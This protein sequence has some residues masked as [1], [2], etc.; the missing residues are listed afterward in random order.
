MR[1]VRFIPSGVQ[2]WYPHVI[3][4]SSTH[5]AY[6]S[7]M[8]IHVFSIDDQSLV[9]IL[10]K[11]SKTI[12]CLAFCPW[13]N[14]KIASASVDGKLGVW[15][16]SY[17]ME[18]TWPEEMGALPL[19]IDWACEPES[20]LLAV[21]YDSGEIRMFDLRSKPPSLKKD[22]Q[23]PS[24]IKAM[25]WH[26]SV[27]GRLICGHLDGTLHL[28]ENP[29]RT[30][31]EPMKTKNNSVEDIQW[32]P[33]SNNY[34]LVSYADGQLQM[35]DCEQ[36]GDPLISFERF[37]QGIRYMSWVPDQPGNFI[38]VSDKSSVIKV[39]NV[40]QKLPVN[41]IKTGGGGILAIKA[42]PKPRN[43]LFIVSHKN[44]STG[45]LDNNKRKMVFTTP[46][47]HS[48]TIFDT[49]FNPVDAD[50]FATASYDGYVKL[51][52][53]STEQSF[54][55]IFAGPT[56]LLYAVSYNPPG[57]LIAAVT[58]SG[59]ILIWNDKGEELCRYEAHKQASIYRLHWHPTYPMIA[60]GGSDQFAVITDVSTISKPMCKTRFRH[61]GTV[62]GVQFDPSGEYLA[63]GCQDGIVRVFRIQTE[64]MERELTGHLGKVFNVTW[65]PLVA[66]VLASGS[67]DKTIRIWDAMKNEQL[68][69]LQG[70]TSYVR[71]LVWHTEC[72]HIII[73]GSW[74]ATIRV[75]NVASETCMQVCPQHQAD[76]YGMV[77]H[78]SRP[79]LFLSCSRDTSLRFWSLD[80]LADKFLLKALIYCGKPTNHP[81]L[82]FPPISTGS[83]QHTDSA[84]WLN[85]DQS[86]LYGQQ[87]KQLVGEIEKMCPDGM[88][89]SGTNLIVLFEKVVSFFHYRKGLSDLWAILCACRGE[90]PCPL[91]PKNGSIHHENEMISRHRTE[92]LQLVAQKQTIGTQGRREDRLQTAAKMLLRVGY[93]EE[94]CTYM[95]LAGQW[96][97]AICM[98]PAVSVEFWQHLNSQYLETLSA[99]ADTDEVAPLYIACEDYDGY[100]N[101]LLHSQ[102][103]DHAFLVAKATADNMYP[104]IFHAPHNTKQESGSRANIHTAAAKLAET[105]IKAYDPLRA[106]L[107][108]FAVSDVQ[109]G[110]NA[111]DKGCETVLIFVVASC[112]Q[113][114][115]PMWVV[116]RLAYTLEA[117]SINSEEC[118]ARAYKNHFLEAAEEMWRHHSRPQKKELF[119]RRFWHDSLDTSTAV[120]AVDAAEQTGDSVSLVFHLTLL[121]PC[122]A[123]DVARSNLHILF[124]NP[125]GFDVTEA[126]LYLEPFESVSLETLPVK[127]IAE[128]LT[129]AAFIGFIDAMQKGYVDIVMPL[130]QTFR[131]LVQHQNLPFPVTLE[132]ITA[133]EQEFYR[134]TVI[135]DSQGLEGM[136][137]DTEVCCFDHWLF[138]NNPLLGLE[139]GKLILTG[140]NLPTESSH[141]KESVLTSFLIKG[142][143]VALDEGLN[144]ISVEEYENWRRVN[145]FSPM[146][147]GQ[148]IRLGNQTY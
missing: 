94:Y 147:T 74:D 129:C 39:W 46:P 133:V 130:A 24:G 68:R 60:T 70:H 47:G 78:P 17:D 6:A 40:S 80:A 86:L 122:R 22:F 113:I 14:D 138:K 25:R 51:W 84:T 19:S 82:S 108:Y 135:A 95:A 59:S 87:S 104:A 134:R 118:Y 110:M 62:I 105:Y 79:F 75:W 85:C 127:A 35:I 123:I 114:Q 81:H 106:S 13:D 18:I 111:L 21:S 93:V 11:H 43:G 146:N 16:L 1:Q 2:S 69:T 10:V 42:V 7:T 32:D 112:L 27:P 102:E 92:A 26:P 109:S 38:T 107:M 20:N 63:T 145:I 72:P 12:T 115:A 117:S 3:T 89:L 96:E 61:P 97:K 34:C 99:V 148:K 56:K 55:E 54:R 71:A 128:I 31:L 44:G 103:L 58:S 121:D 67:D 52:Q 28:L 83:L 141:P 57:T 91:L 66:N 77:A 116:E 120:R 33:L 125:N 48:E 8:A 90:P 132:S 45:I 101:A 50:I 119:Q 140:S 29:K 100:V 23:G 124:M 73:S 126:R 4:A 88:P 131:N 139:R 41:Q 142:D 137:K 65:H 143:A 9:N 76:V 30:K 98:A 36:A 136:A 144:Y 49:C 37:P 64:I 53:V 5:F 15:S